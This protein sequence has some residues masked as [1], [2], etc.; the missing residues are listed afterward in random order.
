LQN[1]PKTL[2]FIDKKDSLSMQGLCL[3]E[4][5]MLKTLQTY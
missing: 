4:T 5:N 3:I 1:K 2:F